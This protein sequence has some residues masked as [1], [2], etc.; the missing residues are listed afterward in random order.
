MAQDIALRNTLIIKADDI[1]QALYPV[2]FMPSM[3]DKTH[4]LIRSLDR[5]IEETYDYLEVDALKNQQR[6][7]V[8]LA[9]RAETIAYEYDAIHK[10]MDKYNRK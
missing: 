5:F 7:L 1:R 4:R 8:T 6:K 9:S 3:T 2:S 10:T